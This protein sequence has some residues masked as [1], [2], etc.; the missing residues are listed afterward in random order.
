MIRG[1]VL[2]SQG[3]E[4]AFTGLLGLRDTNPVNDP[5]GV[6]PGEVARLWLDPEDDWSGTDTG[7]GPHNGTPTEGNGS[8]G[9]VDD[10]NWPNRRGRTSPTKPKW[11][12]DDLHPGGFPTLSTTPNPVPVGD[13]NDSALVNGDALRAALASGTLQ[14]GDHIQ[15]AHGATFAGPFIVGVSGT[16]TDPIV[17]EGEPDYEWWRTG[18]ADPGTANGSSMVTEGG[19]EATGRS[20][21]VFRHL[22]LQDLTVTSTRGFYI[23]GSNAGTSNV[24]I[25]GNKV[26]NAKNSGVA[27]WGASH[28]SGVVTNGVPNYDRLTDVI[29]DSNLIELSQYTSNET[30]T[31]ANGVNGIDVRY[32]ILRHGL[33]SG[34]EG[35]DFKNGVNNGKIHGNIIY[36]L[37]LR[38]IYID[39]GENYRHD[40][41]A[42]S[43]VQNCEIFDNYCLGS[44][45]AGTALSIFSEGV[46]GVK[47]IKIYNNIFREMGYGS[48]GQPYS[49]IH[50]DDH[51]EEGLITDPNHPD[52]IEIESLGAG[53]SAAGTTGTVTPGMPVPPAPLAPM[54]S[55]DLLLCHIETQGNGTTPAMSVPGDWTLVSTVASDTDNAGTRTRHTVYRAWYQ[56]SPDLGVVHSGDHTLAVITAWRGVDPNT[57]IDVSVETSLDNGADTL[58]TAPAIVSSASYGRYAMIV[59]SLSAGA[60][61]T[62]SGLAFPAAGG[63]PTLTDPEQ[64]TVVSTT[65]GSA[66]T[67]GV[68]YGMAHSGLESESGGGFSATTSASAE[69]AAITIALRRDRPLQPPVF[70]GI[71]IYNNTIVDCQQY[72]VYVARNIAGSGG[73]T[74]IEGNLIYGSGDDDHDIRDL[75]GTVSVYN[76]ARDSLGVTY[77]ENPPANLTLPANVTADALLYE[78]SAGSVAVNPSPAL[79]VVAWL[80][81]D[82]HGRPRTSPRDYGAVEYEAP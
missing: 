43:L 14:P 18:I 41:T 19:F 1:G 13:P 35:I 81:H 62:Y 49:G 10:P 30:I 2:A 59:Y 45:H 40:Q 82:F 66:G 7:Q 54:Q 34:N 76:L 69:T 60:A 21:I 6:L 65:L 31:V 22:Y 58:A 24:V 50:I 80:T 39:G 70:E 20:H 68:F 4:S 73:D 42:P 25:Y 56:N 63:D 16:L 48:N 26:R 23:R 29:V 3:I 44:Y 36:D 32:N 75:K 9:V 8:N 11:M 53:T 33:P 67:I 77:N 52:W 57:P 46:G 71:E 28:A 37:R 78:P 15:L 61:V 47:D 51:F 27:I 79:P 74:V 38:C 12:I 55:G 64:R 72:G 17:I 5:A